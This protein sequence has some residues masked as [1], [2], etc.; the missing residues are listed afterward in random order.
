MN[1]YN[2]IL[3]KN[4]YFFFVISTYHRVRQLLL[5][6]WS[7][8]LVHNYHCQYSHQASAHPQQSNLEVKTWG[9]SDS[10][11][12]YCI[13]ESRRERYHPVSVQVDLSN[14]TYI[15]EGWFPHV[16]GGNINVRV[17]MSVWA[18]SWP[19]WDSVISIL[20]LWSWYLLHYCCNA[21]YYREVLQMVT[22]H[23]PYLYT[24]E[25]EKP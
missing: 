21:V 23:R 17:C 7:L 3:L 20:A 25:K 15:Q 16:T 13:S 12:G 22:S 1:E 18:H 14:S 9:Y 6:Q 2:K 8:H 4:I 24:P 19:S 11:A 10:D 5:V